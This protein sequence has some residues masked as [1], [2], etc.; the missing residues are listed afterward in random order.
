MVPLTQLAALTQHPL[1]SILA[2]RYIFPSLFAV[3]TTFY[4]NKYQARK[5]DFV[6]S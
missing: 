1:L 5:T 2:Q 4:G 3:C 6:I